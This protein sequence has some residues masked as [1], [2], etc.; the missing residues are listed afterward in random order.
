MDSTLRIHHIT[1]T[2]LLP[3]PLQGYKSIWRATG[4]QPEQMLVGWL[5]ER[6][7]NL[8]R[9]AP[10]GAFPCSAASQAASFLAK[11]AL[12]HTISVPIHQWLRLRSQQG[13]LEVLSTHLDARRTAPLIQQDRRACIRPPPLAETSEGS[14]KKRRRR[15]LNPARTAALASSATHSEPAQAFKGWT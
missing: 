12:P 4:M 9:L 5:I 14:N 3:P 1:H 8:E 2:R 10:L 13:P 11:L 15:G 6:R 7:F